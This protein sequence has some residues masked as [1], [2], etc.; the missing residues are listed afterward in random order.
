[1]GAASTEYFRARPDVARQV[2]EAVNGMVDEGQVQPIVGMRF[3]L[4]RGADALRLIA[5][6]DAL[7]KVV[8][9]VR[10]AT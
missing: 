1:M 4:E 5:A 10:L 7:G 3:P 2:G 6:R 8:L 9:D